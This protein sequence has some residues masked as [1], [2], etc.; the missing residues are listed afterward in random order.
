MCYS[1]CDELRPGVRAPSTTKFAVPG[2]TLKFTGD[3]ES[4]IRRDEPE[5]SLVGRRL[6]DR[7]RMQ[8]ARR[9]SPT[10]T[11]SGA[12]GFDEI[13]ELQAASA[14]LLTN[15]LTSV[16][17]RLES[18]C[19][20][21]VDQHCSTFGSFTEDGEH[22]LEWT[23]CHAAY[24][25]IVEDTLVQELSVLGCSEDALL[26]HA[27]RAEGDPTAD[28]VLR[29]LIAKTD[30]V[31]FCAMMRRK[32]YEGPSLYEEDGEFVEVPE[33]EEDE[34]DDEGLVEALLGQAVARLRDAEV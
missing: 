25:D 3:E 14:R 27:V 11:M 34:D 23:H 15:S 10:S 26:E 28:E 17:K 31:R 9:V 12:D 20:Q 13:S 30:Y 29:R 1:T 24:C 7:A 22:L 4:R 32:A 6:G 21:F 18:S 33:D 19:T 16:L 8:V 2:V 5:A